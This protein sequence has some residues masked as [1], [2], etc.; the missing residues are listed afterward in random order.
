MKRSALLARL[1]AQPPAESVVDTP[2]PLSQLEVG[3]AATVAVPPVTS[4]VERTKP[5]TQRS[6]SR[7]AT[8]YDLVMRYVATVVGL[9]LCAG[10]WYAGAYFT[11]QWLLGL[12]PQLA[13][14]AWLLP[15]AITGGEAG[16]WP[17]R[18]SGKASR[19]LFLLLLGFD[20]YTTAA[21]IFPILPETFDVPVLWILAGVLGVA[22]AL[23]PEKMAL[24]LVQENIAYER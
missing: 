20:A 14:Y 17:R 11:V 21:G 9:A 18:V 8:T 10:A 22:L 12:A 19:S 24:A 15:L 3:S 7:V 6:K 1:I 13:G 2:L 16:F 4:Q 23:V 5:R